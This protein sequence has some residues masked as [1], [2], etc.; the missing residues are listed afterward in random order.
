MANIM[1]MKLPFPI[2][3]RD[4]FEK[5]EYETGVKDTSSMGHYGVDGIMRGR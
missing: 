1:E 2:A 4:G 5:Y 3:Y